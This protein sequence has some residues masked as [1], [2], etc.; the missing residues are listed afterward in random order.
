MKII[1]S[2]KS[3]A[4]L[5]I[6]FFAS[7]PLYAANYYWVGGSGNWHD[8]NH[9]RTTS[10]GSTRPNTLPSYADDVYFDTYSGFTVGNNRVN[11]KNDTAYFTVNCRNITFKNCV[12]PPILEGNNS[13]AIF[14][15]S[16]WQ[17]GMEINLLDISYHNSGI[18]K[19]IKS[20]GVTMSVIN[21]VQFGEKTSISLL[22]DLSIIGTLSLVDGAFRTRNHTVRV[23]KGGQYDALGILVSNFDPNAIIVLD[24]GSSSVFIDGGHLTIQKNV[25]ITLNAG[26]S[27]IYFKKGLAQYS[28]MN[29]EVEGLIFNNVTL[30][31]EAAIVSDFEVS[32]AVRFNR[33]EFKKGGAVTGN[34]IFNELIFSEG[35]EYRFL[36]YTNRHNI[37]IN[38]WVLGGSTCNLTTVKG[39]PRANVNIT[40]A[41][42]YFNF[43]N[44]TGLNAVGKPLRFN[45]R[46]VDG[47]GNTNIT[48]DTPNTNVLGNDWLCHV[49]DNNNPNTYTITTDNFY[50]DRATIYKWYKISGTNA[51]VSTVIATTETIDIRNF[52][53][54]GT[55]KVVVSYLGRDGVTILCETAST[56]NVVEKTPKPTVVGLTSID[57]K[58]TGGV[59]FCKKQTNTLADIT[60]IGTNIKW[61]ATET[62]IRVLS[63]TTVLE[64]G[65]TYYVTQT[66]DDCE[67]DRVAVYVSIKNCTSPRINPGIRMRVAN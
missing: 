46:S 67:S 35:H 23:Q 19:T 52:D 14:G 13:L 41:T 22:D 37:E 11:I 5:L 16:E 21:S 15:S 17:T 61:Y 12:V 8:L 54:Y 57:G 28:G 60:V 43:A 48:F 31:D 39:A 44:I 2:I 36:T 53:G 7:V 1:T 25:Q 20:N 29:I 38:S 51:S 10:G 56:I 33:V 24:L 30:L 34:H 3:I 42:T 27:H 63:K 4:L 55:Y 49:I 65:Q 45:S 50:K 64:D 18:P 66:V 62:S 59:V 9:W 47:G 32:T 6:L 40:G 26:T 58:A